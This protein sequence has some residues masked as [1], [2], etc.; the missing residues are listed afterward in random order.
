MTLAKKRGI[1]LFTAFILLFTLA[2]VPTMKVSA[3]TPAQQEVYD[4]SK[5]I[6]ALN[7][8]QTVIATFTYMDVTPYGQTDIVFNISGGETITIPGTA[9]AG[10]SAADLA[11]V[12]GIE[13]PFKGTTV[14]I[15]LPAATVT[16]LT[17]SLPE[18]VGAAIGGTYTA[19]DGFTLTTDPLIYIATYQAIHGAI[20][21]GQD[22][23]GNL[24]TRYGSSFT[25]AGLTGQATAPTRLDIIKI[26]DT[27]L[28][29]K[30]ATATLTINASA[31]GDA[32]TTDV[33]TATVSQGLALANAGTLT[34]SYTAGDE[35]AVTVTSPTAIPDLDGYTFDGLYADPGFTLSLGTSIADVHYVK[36]TTVYAKYT[37]IPKPTP[38]PFVP[39]DPIPN[40]VPKAGT[41][42]TDT[43]TGTGTGT[44]T[45]TTPAVDTTP[46]A[47]VTVD[48]TPSEDGTLTLTVGGEE[49]ET[50]SESAAEAIADGTAK[51]VVVSG[52]A[53]AVVTEDNEVI[54]GANESGSMNSAS[55]VNALKAAAALLDE[56]E[57]TVIIEAGEDVTAISA[58]TLEKLAAAAAA[59]GVEATISATATDESGAPVATLD[60]PVSE[61][62]G[63]VKT[64]LILEDATIDSAVAALEKS[65]GTKVLASFKTEQKTSFGAA[66]TF[67]VDTGALGLEDIEDGATLYIA[68]KLANGKTVQITGTVIGGILTFE[69]ARAGTFMISDQSFAKKK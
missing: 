9:I 53:V 42:L 31:T 49:V 68:I 46:A 35:T 26:G 67:S 17:T 57:K 38:T 62:M 60:I 32:G 16:T 21:L 51:E 40:S 41:T 3:A 34:L 11:G 61:D 36:D 18:A 56:S 47:D 12:N 39:A 69:T 44:G 2:I 1:A 37:E 27:V 13:V 33:Y 8:T 28:T 19:L 14:N 4:V 22:A 5:A 20:R 52:A 24:T 50:F 55:T 29:D 23:S 45:G 54:A 6:D 15:K 48:E 25:L 59:A 30:Y 58:S 43:D 65:T 64:G 63:D 10:A 7:K 66:T